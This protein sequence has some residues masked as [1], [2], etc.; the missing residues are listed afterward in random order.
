MKQQ[1][2]RKLKTAT[3]NIDPAILEEEIHA[4]DHQS[5]GKLNHTINKRRHFKK[6]K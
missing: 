5:S 2:H 4:I 1:P 3:L 6:A